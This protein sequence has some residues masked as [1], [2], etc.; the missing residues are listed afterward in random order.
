MNY[1]TQIVFVL[2]LT[3]SILCSQM[4]TTDYVKITNTN[5]QNLEGLL[6]KFTA[7]KD[8][9]GMA[10]VYKKMAELKSYTPDAKYEV[11]ELSLKAIEYF[12]HHDELEKNWEK[13]FLANLFS[14]FY[15]GKLSLEYA[16]K[17]A[18]NAYNYALTNKNTKLEISA[19]QTIFRLG[20]IL[21]TNT[22][23]LENC[24]KLCDSL[25][26]RNKIDDIGQLKMYHFQKGQY[27]LNSNNLAEATKQFNQSIKYSKKNVDSVFITTCNLFKTNI[28]RFEKKSY[29]ALK[30]LREDI[31]PNILNKNPDLQRWALQENALN[32]AAIGN[33][34]LANKYWDKHFHIQQ[35]ILENNLNKYLLS[36]AISSI[37]AE[38]QRKENNKLQ[39]NN[40][41]NLEK[42]KNYKIILFGLLSLF[43]LGLIFVFFR[44]KWKRMVD[45]NIKTT[46]LL[47]GQELERNRLSKELHDGVGSS[48]AAIKTNLYFSEKSPERNQ[49]LNLLD[50]LYLK[51]RDISHQIYPAYLITDG[52]TM[53][54]NDFLHMINGDGKIV[55]THFGN[56]PKIEANKILN[57]FRIIQELL[58]NAIRHANATKIELEIMYQEGSIFMRI[59]DNGIGFD[60]S[61]END[62]I[63]LKNIQNRLNA[64]DGQLE[65]I[66]EIKKGTTFLISM[67]N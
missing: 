32:N 33:S 1:N 27:A 24:L 58:N 2:M 17:H 6:K 38:N 29:M 19:L 39:L 4:V 64:V 44:I 3:S 40:T 10:Y 30:I 42:T 41:L 48:L 11:V 16:H 52:L 46:F 51:V 59:Q 20:L 13:I 18:N 55:F 65:C 36:D 61:L 49:L 15:D 23:N 28:N 67:Q 31:Y 26:I 21:K 7:Q 9:L 66:S 57:I 8:T 60:Q 50:D 35:N 45:K 22:I 5:Q 56:E 14:E 37:L 25:F 53:A 12:A 63:G 47:E 43:V 62:G 34:V 54:L